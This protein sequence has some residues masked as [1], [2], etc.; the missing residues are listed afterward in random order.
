MTYKIVTISNREPQEPYY[1]YKEFFKSLYGESILLLG[2]NNGE[3]SGLSDKPRI[4]YNA[5]KKGLISEDIIVFVDCWDIVFASGLEEVISNFKTFNS[6]VVVGAEKNCYPQN[7]KKEF[8]RLQCP[9]SYKYLNSGV[10]IGYTDAILTI[11]EAMDAPQLPVDYWNGNLNANYHFNDQAYYMDIYLRQ[12]VDIELDHY[13]LIA[14]NMQDVTED[15]LILSDG[16]IQNKE[17]GT[18]PCIIHWN[19]SSK[20]KW[21]REPILKHLKLV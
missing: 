4:L 5:I 7:F 2:Q 13:C 11:L 3:Y 19:G 1:T 12:P 15:E 8:D 16:V 20:D 6:S 9:T 17:T 10:I 21:S 14:Q 18:L